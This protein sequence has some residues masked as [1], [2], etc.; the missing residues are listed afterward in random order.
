MANK[1]TL[2]ER[3]SQRV[4]PNCGGEP[5]RKS[6]KG[7]VPTYCDD[8]CKVQMNNRLTAEGRTLAGLLKAWRIDRGQGE[9]AQ[10]AFS[11]ICEITDG[12]NAVDLAAG[13]PRADL[14]AAKL[15]ADGSRYLDRQRQPVH[16]KEA[17]A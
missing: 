6:P 3:A 10:R 11:Q 2:R 17:S 9:I 5:Q 12:F 13:R 4:C 1:P 14:Y 8:K 16:S 7:P 15:M